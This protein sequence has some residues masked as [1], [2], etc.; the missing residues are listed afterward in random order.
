MTLYASTVDPQLLETLVDAVNTMMAELPYYVALDAV[1]S[2]FQ[3]YLVAQYNETN[4]T[5]YLSEIA[6]VFDHLNYMSNNNLESM[7]GYP[8]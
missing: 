3:K 8:H 1:A 2:Q 6:K 7:I 5:Y 4:D